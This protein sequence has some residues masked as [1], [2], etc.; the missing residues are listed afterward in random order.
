MTSKSSSHTQQP[1]IQQMQGFTLIE[2]MV[3]LAI[4]AILAVLA[5]PR[6][7]LYVTQSHTN[8]AKPYLQSLAA[9]ERVYF[10]RHGTY[11]ASADEDS[12]ETTLGVDLNDA[13]NFCF[14]VRTA[15][16]ITGLNVPPVQF[17]I[18][19][20]LRS[21]NVAAG[22][23]A[24]AVDGGGGLNCTSTA[25]KLPSTGWVQG[26]GEQGGVGRVVVYRYPAPVNGFD[27]VNT[28]SLRLGV[29]H[30]WT[31]GISISN[32]MQP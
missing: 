20:V 26:A 8:D 21:S 25:G 10:N 9:K 6:Y 18:W 2:L 7:T 27:A 11:F 19:A 12:L 28:D 1:P 5:V 24:V 3:V 22:G 15:N 16:F 30:N 13:A 23:D 17:E 31:D 32:V 14:I 29:N 4:I